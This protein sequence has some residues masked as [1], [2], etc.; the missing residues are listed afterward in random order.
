MAHLSYPSAD[1][2]QLV[3]NAQEEAILAVVRGCPW[4]N[5]A[6]VDGR[7]PGSTQVLSV[8]LTT[9]RA[10]DSTLRRI[11]QMCSG[12]IFPKEGGPGQQPVR[13]NPIPAGNKRSLAK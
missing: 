8:T 9:T 13:E 12:L 11:L 7:I 4:W 6:T 10:M 1:E 2:V 3:L 5:K